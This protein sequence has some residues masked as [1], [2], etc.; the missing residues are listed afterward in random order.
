MRNAIATTCLVLGT[1]LAPVAAFAADG[2][3]DRA[4]PATFVKDSVIT[5]KIKTKL[6]AEHPGSAKHIKVDTDQNGIV[7]MTGTANTAGRSEPGRHDRQEHRGRED[8]QE[9]PQG[10]EG[11]LT[12]ARNGLRK[13]EARSASFFLSSRSRDA[14]AARS[15]AY[16]RDAHEKGIVAMADLRRRQRCLQGSKSWQRNF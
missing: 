14:S 7:W 4:N 12:P 1:M 3:T 5:T 9:R 16:R 10:P 2:D 13:N 15:P 6:A 11:P 8:G